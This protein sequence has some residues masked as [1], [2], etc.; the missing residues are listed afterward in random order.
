MA[1]NYK[2]TL[3]LPI[4]AFPMRANLGKREPARVEHW[5]SIDL[6]KKIQAQNADG[7]SF[8]LHDGPPFTNG[9]LHLG[10]AL[11]KSLKEIVLR[12]KA[13]RG[14]RTPYIPGWDCHG[15][16]IEWKIEEQYKKKKKNKDEVPIK[17]FRM[18]CR[19]FAK[20]WIE[21]HIKEFKRLG[22]VGDFKNY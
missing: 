10:H 9:D 16:P 3:K 2:N 13:A 21:V 15:L 22:V 5:E 8:I 4:T 7:P 17:D 11:N 6:Y 1:E 20:S 12:Y 19:E 14:F 18:E